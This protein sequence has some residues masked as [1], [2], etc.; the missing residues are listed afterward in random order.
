MKHRKKSQL[1]IL[2]LLVTTACGKNRD[3]KVPPI[4]PQALDLAEFSSPTFSQLSWE[5]KCSG[6]KT[7]FAD[8]QKKYLPN[9]E[10]SFSENTCRREYD[11]DTSYLHIIEP[12]FTK[13]GQ[14]LQLAIY[15][16]TKFKADTF[17]LQPHSAEID[18]RRSNDRVGFQYGVDDAF[19]GENLI[20]LKET[21]KQWLTAD[22]DKPT[23]VFGLS[24]TNYLAQIEMRFGA[25]SNGLS[26]T[27]PN[28]TFKLMPGPQGYYEGTVV[29]TAADLSNYVIDLANGQSKPRKFLNCLDLACL[30]SSYVTY[31][32]V[33]PALALSIPD[34]VTGEHNGIPIYEK[35][36]FTISLDFLRPR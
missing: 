34:V 30:S 19:F 25:E 20:H 15:L 24:Y 2:T 13:D 36:V 6:T 5:D 32:V 18:R 10:L 7:F 1:F 4:T 27:S 16:S 29:F 35:Q 26:L 8:F 31:K 22:A 23:Q 33:G 12:I 11:L 28:V 14:V 21:F 17:T 9:V 3:E